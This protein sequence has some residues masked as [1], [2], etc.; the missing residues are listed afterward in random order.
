MMTFQ[1][2]RTGVYL[3]TLSPWSCVLS[4]TIRSSAGEGRCSPII[5]CHAVTWFVRTQLPYSGLQQPGCGGI[6]HWK[7]SHMAFSSSGHL[8]VTTIKAWEHC[9]DS[10]CADDQNCL[11]FLRLKLALERSFLAG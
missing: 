8:T 7:F 2:Q 9:K 1:F 11:P 5:H 6:H 3:L 4:R 10:T